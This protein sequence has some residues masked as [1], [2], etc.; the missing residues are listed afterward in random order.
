MPG[1]S[2]IPFEAHPFTIASIPQDEE[3][4]NNASFNDGNELVFFVG[5]QGGFTRRLRDL[6]GCG[7]GDKGIPLSV[8]VDGPY[9]SPPDLNAFKTVILIAGGI[10][11]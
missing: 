8:Y 4:K 3:D 2:T 5:T 9:G 7:S 6:V 10:V 1:V 11:Y